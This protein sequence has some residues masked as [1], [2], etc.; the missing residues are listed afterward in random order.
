[1]ETPCPPAYT[2]LQYIDNIFVIWKGSQDDLTNLFHNINKQNPTIK[3]D[4][5]ISFVVHFEVLFE[6]QT[7]YQSSLI[8]CYQI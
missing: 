6:R 3:F 8:F 4:V 5:V 7:K 1:M 2:Y